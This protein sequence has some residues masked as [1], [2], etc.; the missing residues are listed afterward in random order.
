MFLIGKQILGKM[1]S[2]SL[3]AFKHNI[4]QHYF[5]DLKEKDI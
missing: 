3:N 2:A 4:K 5:N 1:P